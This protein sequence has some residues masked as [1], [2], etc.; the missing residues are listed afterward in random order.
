M[1][2]PDLSFDDSKQLKITTE[3]VALAR[4]LHKDITG[5]LVRQQDVVINWVRRELPPPPEPPDEP[6]DEEGDV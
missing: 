1:V 6:S 5:L 2:T 4:G 3:T